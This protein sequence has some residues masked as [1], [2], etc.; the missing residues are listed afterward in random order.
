VTDD[1]QA[2][3]TAKNFGGRDILGCTL[4]TGTAGMIG[5]S[6]FEN[7]CRDGEPVIGTY[8]RPTVR[9]EEIDR[10]QSLIEL[11]VRHFDQVRRLV[12]EYR[13]QTIFHLAA[14]SLPTVSWQRPRE[15]IDVN[16]LGTVSLF[17]AVKAV[18]EVG[19]GYDPIIVVA[20]SSAEYGASLRP[21]N[22]PIAEDAALLPLNPYG[23]SKVAQDLLTFQYWNSDAIRGIRARIFNTTGPG[24]RD[25]VV[26]DLARRI[27][28]MRRQGGGRLRVGNTAS[29]RA[30]LDVRDTVT[31]LRRLAASGTAGEAYNICADEAYSVSAVIKAFERISGI[32]LPI[33]VDPLLLRPTDEPVIFGDNSKLKATTGWRQSIKLDEMLAAVLDYEERALARHAN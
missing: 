12:G 6:L 7:L 1:L 16:V 32:T 4:I 21:E 31:A 13:P 22:V 25:D 23:V 5:S 18:R 29:R 10:W 14:Q 15:T 30:I 28:L 20:C 33:E 2:S 8:L 24:K 11:D 9:L 19:A 26:S 27:A 3:T 17:E